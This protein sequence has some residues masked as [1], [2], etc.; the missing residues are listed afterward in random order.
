MRKTAIYP[1][2]QK[3]GKYENKS[4]IQVRYLNSQ[5]DVQFRV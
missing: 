1:S 4:A 5:S 2:S 3:M